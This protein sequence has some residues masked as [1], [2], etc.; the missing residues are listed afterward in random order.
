MNKKT[1]RKN[2]GITLIAL[3]ISIIVLL[4]LAG[5]SIATLTGE[6]GILTQAQHAK[7]TSEYGQ[8]E[9]A[10][11]LA[12][13]STSIDRYA[14]D[15]TITLEMI[16]GQLIKDGY[17][18]EKRSSDESASVQGIN[19]SNTNVEIA[20]RES[21]TVEVTLEQSVGADI[22]YYVKQDGKYYEIVMQEDTVE[23]LGPVTE[24]EGIEI[25]QK[26]ITVSSSDN[27]IISATVSGTTITL[28]A[29]GS[30]GSVIITVKYGD[31]FTKTCAAKIAEPNRLVRA[32]D[33]GS[34]GKYLGS[35][36]IKDKIETI[37]FELGKEEPQGVVSSFDASEKQDESI[38]GCYT[39]ND[40]NGL[41]EL[42]FLS[43]D[44][45]VVN[46]NASYLFKN[47]IKLKSIEF[48]NFSTSGATNMGEM[49]YECS[50]LTT[51][52]LSNFDTSQVTNMTSMFGGCTS[53][54]SLN[55][56]NFNTQ[57]VT[58]MGYMFGWCSS[59]R[60]LDLSDFDTH[61]VTSMS[62]MFTYCL[63]LTSLD[64]SNF[65]TDSVTTMQEMFYNCSNIRI[66]D[67]SS[68]S[69]DSVTN[70]V[71]MFNL[72]QSLTTIYAS[73]LWK[74]DR[75][76]YSSWMFSNCNNLTGGNGTKHNGGIVDKTYARIDTPETPG[77]FT[78]ILDKTEQ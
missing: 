51:L 5:V 21:A 18:I 72:C 32:G 66:I 29:V 56:N 15:N 2:E 30:T 68:F 41:Y 8:I 24:P 22:K 57:N 54:T 75:V 43:D 44:T 76:I 20:E 11:N 69:A 64:I 40:G 46:K 67:L 6:N 45:I 4:I 71:N 63:S 28:N 31:E 12:Y 60:T 27:S 38:I 65:N 74:N 58:S 70:T 39:D 48:N 78:N 55:V 61:S 16:A 34:T 53:L 23:V 17:K 1:K 49:F 9:E 50:N 14:H 47:L 35:A 13:A 7:E 59:L 37:S 25:I 73:D 36:I 77:Y 26:E 10:V 62:K 19:L 33:I 42:T 3:V 52:D